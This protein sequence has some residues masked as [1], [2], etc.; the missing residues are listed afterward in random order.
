MKCSKSD[1]SYNGLVQKAAGYFKSSKGFDRL[2]EKMKDKYRSMGRIGGSVKLLDLSEEEKE[3][4]TG[5]LGKNCYKPRISIKLEK[6][7]SALE[8]TPFSGVS[9]VDLICEYFEEDVLTREAEKLMHERQK[10]EFFEEIIESFAGSSSC[11]WLVKALS[12]GDAG[13]RTI[14]KRYNADRVAL[15]HDIQKV[16]HALSNLPERLGKK[17]RLAIFASE[18]GDGPHDFD[19]GGECDKL[20]MHA[21]SDIYGEKIPQNAEERAYLLYGAGIVIDEVSNFTICSGIVGY[22]G[23][24]E[25]EGWMGFCQRGEPLQVSVSNLGN[26]DSVECRFDRVFVVE[27]PAVFSEILECSNIKSPPL[28][29]TFGQ[30]KLAS[31]ILLDMLSAQ[32]TQIWYSGDFDP[33]GLQIAMKLK[34]RYGK[35]FVF[36]RYASC[37]YEKA[38]S[39]IFI[40]PARMKKLGGFENTELEDIAKAIEKKGFAGYQENIV[41]E[42]ICD[43]DGLA[44]GNCNYAGN[45]EWR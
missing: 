39:S 33:E 31:L 29:C 42:L 19:R 43:V 5:L 4:L 34:E 3:S 2:F 26:V 6:V 37:D 44:E 24:E 18:W 23:E 14:V 17:Q 32:G 11:E 36:W 13:R 16:M 9:L 45:L 38:V 15:R 21:L 8:N 7:Q 27:N 41:K 22:I 10:D 1:D 30:V 20:F 35:G 28:V 40:D 12:N 25:H